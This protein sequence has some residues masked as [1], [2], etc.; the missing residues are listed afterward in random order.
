MPELIPANIR[1]ITQA[2]RSLANW[3]AETTRS[4]EPILI[5]QRGEPTGVLLAADHWRAT[6]DELAALRARAGRADG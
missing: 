4:G 1:P 3:I 2:S 6:M 5:T